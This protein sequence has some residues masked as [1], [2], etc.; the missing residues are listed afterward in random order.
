MRKS[1]A[2]EVSNTDPFAISPTA[3]IL[4]HHAQSPRSPDDSPFLHRSFSQQPADSPFVPQGYARVAGDEFNEPQ[5]DT[6]KWWTRYIYNNGMEDK[7][8]ARSSVWS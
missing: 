5:L 6:S 2:S 1:S 7:L 3:P 4:G 8:N